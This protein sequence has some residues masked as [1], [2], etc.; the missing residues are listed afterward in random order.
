MVTKYQLLQFCLAPACIIAAMICSHGI[1]A[2]AAEEQAI[3]TLEEHSA[4][5]VDK[6]AREREV[7]LTLEGGLVCRQARD[8]AASEAGFFNTKTGVFESLRETFKGFKRRS[9]MSGLQSYEVRSAILQARYEIHHANFECRQSIAKNIRGY[10]KIAE[11]P[12]Y[13]KFQIF[14]NSISPPTPPNTFKE[15][16]TCYSDESDG[17]LSP[18]IGFR[19]IPLRARALAFVLVNSQNEI[20]WAGS[21]A[22]RLKSWDAELPEGLLPGSRQGRYR[23]FRNSFRSSGY[24]APCPEAGTKE[25][26]K[27]HGYALRVANFALPSR[28]DFKRLDRRLRALSLVRKDVWS[29][30]YQAPANDGDDG[31][32]DS[33]A[34]ATPTVPPT[35][36]VTPTATLTPTAT[37][38]PTLTPTFTPTSTPTASPTETPTY[39]PTVTPTITP[40]NTPTFTPTHTPTTTPT[41]T[42]TSTPT[43]SQD[44]SPSNSSWWD[45][46][47]A[48]S[49]GIFNTNT[50]VI[51]GINTAIQLRLSEFIGINSADG[52]IIR[53][54]V[55][56]ATVVS[57]NCST[58]NSEAYSQFNVSEGDTV[59]FEVEIDQGNMGCGDPHVLWLKIKN[60]SDSLN[61]LDYVGINDSSAFAPGGDW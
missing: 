25:E 11:S 20:L 1:I 41:D 5:E 15:I 53:A 9:K 35:N 12:K 42:P 52:C 26:F 16:V 46:V 43:S 30:F 33:S 14:S 34:T 38:T 59:Y 50:V 61:V 22:R 57:R 28:Y 17:G 37:N 18:H 48:C 6:L 7:F 21:L 40:T 27:L 56:G 44:T 8:G 60:A 45:D 19:Y 23:R 32:D 55:N 58:A 4:T 2:P 47:V 10:S 3:S 31:D 24:S 39:T 54:V 49:D 51:A 29:A 13:T 36:T